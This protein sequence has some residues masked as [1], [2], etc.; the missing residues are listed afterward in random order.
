MH[1]P[2]LGRSIVH[3][4]FE[5]V[6]HGCKRVRPAAVFLSPWASAQEESRDYVHR[7]LDAVQ[8]GRG[9]FSVAHTCSTGEVSVVVSLV[10]SM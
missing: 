2:S 6:C 7:P 1:A 3:C 5:G 8:G 4:A 9:H 10:D